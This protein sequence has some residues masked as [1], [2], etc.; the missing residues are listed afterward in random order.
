VKTG[1]GMTE[2][3]EFGNGERIREQRKNAGRIHIWEVSLRGRRETSEENTYY[4]V[5]LRRRRENSEK[6]IRGKRDL[7][8]N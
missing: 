1:T 2:K 6:F 4:E 5:S 7:K 3:R 8:I